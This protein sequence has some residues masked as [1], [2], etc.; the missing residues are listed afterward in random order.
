MAL[1]S[2]LAKR[3]TLLVRKSEGSNPS[4]V[5]NFCIPAISLSLFVREQSFSKISEMKRW[6]QIGLARLNLVDLVFPNAPSHQCITSF[7]L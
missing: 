7:E 4:V 5:N 3:K 6:R 1:V 2:G